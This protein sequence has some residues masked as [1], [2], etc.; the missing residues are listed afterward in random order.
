MCFGFLIA[1]WHRKKEFKIFALFLKQFFLL[2]SIEISI[3][4]N[5]QKVS[6]VAKTI[7]PK[8]CSRIVLHY[9]WKFVCFTLINWCLL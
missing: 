2:D 7:K 5:W 8:G 4:R 6:E 3:L 1:R 9:T